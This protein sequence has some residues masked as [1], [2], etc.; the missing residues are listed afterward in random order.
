MSGNSYK[1]F[2]STFARTLS[3]DSFLAILVDLF[4]PSGNQSQN[5]IKS[6][7]FQ[8]CPK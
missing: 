4:F 5:L 8:V 1:L 2:I 7:K 6:A 3:P